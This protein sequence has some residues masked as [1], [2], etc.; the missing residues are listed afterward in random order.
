LK[1]DLAVEAEVPLMTRRGERGVSRSKEGLRVR[2]AQSFSKRVFSFFRAGDLITKKRNR[3]SAQKASCI[4]CLR[5][6]MGI[7][8][9]SLIDRE[10][11]P[12]PL[13]EDGVT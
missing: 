6:W 1:H 10:E 13:P 4:M 3:L 5:A 2:K 8:E 12:G 9:R 7:K 11:E